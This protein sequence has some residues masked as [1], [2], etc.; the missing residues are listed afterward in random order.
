MSR[1]SPTSPK[2]TSC[3][4]WRIE[5]A[6]LSETLETG[7]TLTIDLGALAANWRLLRDRS[8]AA[9]CAAVV[10]A[11]A[12]GIG[13]EPAVGALGRAGCRTFFVAHL[14]E[15]ARVRAVVPEAVIYVL[16]G[17]QPGTA[18]RYRELGL[19]PVLGSM[20]EIR[21]WAEF[22]GGTKLPAAL[23]VDTGMN[24]L[25]LT[26]AEAIALAGDPVVSAFE[27]AL[28]M[29]HLAASEEPSQPINDRQVA[30]FLAVAAEYP[31]VPASLANSSGVFLADS[32]PPMRGL[33][34][35][36]P[37]YALYGGNPTPDR[38]NPMQPVVRLD[39]RIIQVREIEAGAKAGYN[40][41]WTAARPSRLATLSIGY[42]DGYPRS[43]SGT[44]AAIRADLPVGAALVAGRLCPFVGRVSMDLIILDVT[45]LPEREVSRGD[46]AVLIGGPLDINE[47]GRRAGT[48]GY[49]ILTNLGRRYT[50]HYVQD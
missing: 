30:T 18:A 8:S 41:T 26:P 32:F 9:E 50:R 16:N 7:A 36:R 27:P 5:I 21:E 6:R 19:R 48:I 49:E 28:L 3:R 11:D 13:I 15:A 43:A 24:R 47:V 33:A 23:H 35:A 39:A 29:S 10:K 31:G 4:S 22:C 20:P 42:A 2:R 44:D 37:G 34:L 1:A 38:P 12:Y 46:P 25:G 40:E 45:D 17:L 14:S